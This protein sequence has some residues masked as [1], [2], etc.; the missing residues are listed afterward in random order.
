MKFSPDVRILAVLIAAWA[1][2]WGFI[3][4]TLPVMPIDETRYLT[5][6][7]EM[8]LQH[9][10]IL[11]TLNFA[12]YSHKPPL[13]FWLINLAWTLTGGPA[14]WSARIVPLF[15][16]GGVIAGTYILARRLFPE[17]RSAGIYAALILAASPFIYIYGGLLM[18]DMLNA[19]IGLCA[20]G[21]VWTA[22]RTGQFRWWIFWG[23]AVGAGVLAKGP[24]I[25]IY[26]VFPALLAPLWHRPA[27]WLKW[28]TGLLTGVIVAAQIGLAWA[29]PAAISG[30]PEYAQMIFWKQSAGRMVNAF[31]HRRSALFYL[32]LLPLM[33]LPLLML[34]SWWGAMRSNMRGIAREKAGRFLLCWVLP[35]FAC[36]LMISG[37]QA[38]YLI[39]LLPGAAMFFA[40]A[41]ARREEYPGSVSGPFAF[42]FTVLLVLLVIPHIPSFIPAVRDHEYAWSIIESMSPFLTIAALAAIAGLYFAAR[43][44]E[45]ARRLLCLPLLMAVFFMHFQIQGTRRAFDYYDLTPLAAAL[46]EH[47]HRPLAFVRNY[48]G[49]AGF[50]ARL[51]RAITPLPDVAHL[52]QWFAENPGAA[53]V[54]RTRPAAKE[55]ENFHVLFSQPYRSATK[56]IALVEPK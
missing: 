22:A 42:V 21:A 49:E 33:F 50:V 35:P 10:W 23:L 12:P 13:L 3:A 27:S 36:L 15:V 17:N 18:F 16:T 39:P 40:A 32:P 7:W 37:K 43:R 41:M 20:A 9:S 19:L 44:M 14:G 46:Q 45:G 52:P 51:D 48:E 53:A 4:A 55:M 8:R 30:G 28:Y 29:I 11:P 5:V 1:V 54:V 34:P 2:T 24:V 47:K 6:A 31:D 38:H 56:I 26:T 25:L